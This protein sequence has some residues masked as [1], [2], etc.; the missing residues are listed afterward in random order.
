PCLAERQ[1]NLCNLILRLLSFYLTSGKRQS[2][3]RSL[4]MTMTAQQVASPRLPPG[5]A[6]DVD[7]ELERSLTNEWA[8]KSVT[9]QN[10]QCP[11]NEWILTRIRK[12]G[13]SLDDLN[14]LHKVVPQPETFKVTK[15]LCADT[16]LPEFRRIL[17]R[18]VRE[19][20]VPKG[21]LRTPVAV[22]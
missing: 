17:N 22:Q 21:R 7:A 20:V 1:Q 9:Y 19:V 12:M 8:D 5:Q 14:Y 18:F 13:Y 10:N 11:L 15:Q 4:T 16:N 2:V 6:N 3:C